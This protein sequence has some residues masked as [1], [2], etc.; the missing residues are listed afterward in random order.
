MAGAAPP[1]RARRTRSRTLQSPAAA[2]VSGQRSAVSGSNVSTSSL[3]S[4]ACR[5]TQRSLTASLSLS[6]ALGRRPSV[7]QP[8]G[9]PSTPR[10]CAAAL[11]LS[12]VRY[13]ATERCRRPSPTSTVS[14]FFCVNVSEPTASFP[15]PSPR[16][17][18][19]WT[20]QRCIIYNSISP[21]VFL[22]KTARVPRH[23][24]GR[25]GENGASVPHR[26]VEW[27]EGESTLYRN[28]IYNVGCVPLPL[29]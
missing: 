25:T 16:N 12:A 21:V 20:K 23:S 13:G 1:V 28:N 29:A 18:R 8:S 15:A 27:R 9:A 24:L 14:S 26:R 17:P 7:P 6:L 22:T 3:L 5:G 2:A 10:H 4:L 11:S 19:F